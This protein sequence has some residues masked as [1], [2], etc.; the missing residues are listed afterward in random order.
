[1]RLPNFDKE[2]LKEVCIKIYLFHFKRFNNFVYLISKK[3]DSRNDVKNLLENSQGK[4]I[5]ALQNFK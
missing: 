1:M 4:W 5:C 3:N 2:N